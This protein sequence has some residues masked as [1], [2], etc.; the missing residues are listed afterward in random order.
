MLLFESVGQRATLQA[1][2]AIL[3]NVF[4]FLIVICGVVLSALTL[5]A[6]A[7][8]RYLSADPADKRPFSSAV[9]AGNTLYVSGHLG[10]D[11]ATN[12]APTDPKVEIR[13]VMDAVKASVELA[14]FRMDDLVSVQ[15]F[16]TDLALYDVFNEAYRSYFHG[17]YPARAFIG[18]DKLLRGAR[19]EVMGIAVKDGH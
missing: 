13:N 12:S 15:I 14:G 16:C 9:L 4:K 1:G 10:L 8:K 7:P 3:T 19:F 5:A 6:D 2:R 18:T 11:P 17:R